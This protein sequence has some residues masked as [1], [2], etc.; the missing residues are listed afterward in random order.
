MAGEPQ[1]LSA[2]EFGKE[3]FQ[4]EVGEL[5]HPA[6][7]STAGFREHFLPVT[8]TVMLFSSIVLVRCFV[9]S[10]PVS[11]TVMLF[12]RLVLVRCSEF[13]TCLYAFMDV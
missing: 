11:A 1:L 13:L 7:S 2:R 8:A 6:S 9:F 5:A 12:S 10:L 4:V 3:F